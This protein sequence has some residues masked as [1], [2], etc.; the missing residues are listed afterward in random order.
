MK[1]LSKCHFYREP[2]RFNVP[3]IAEKLVGWLFQPARG[4]CLWYKNGLP[5]WVE[6]ADSRVSL[7]D[8]SHCECFEPEEDNHMGI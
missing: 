4:N 6:T 7:T 5:V 3:P 1:P 8:C 2:E